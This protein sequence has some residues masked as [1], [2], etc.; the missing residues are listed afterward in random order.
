MCEGV[1]FPW[2]VQQSS[3]GWIH[4]DIKVCVITH[5][6]IYEIISGVV[7]IHPQ[8]YRRGDKNGQAPDYTDNT[9]TFL[10]P[11]HTHTLGTRTDVREP[12]RRSLGAACLSW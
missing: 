5:T 1:Y 8:T 12:R 7:I 9:Q 3:K 6:H 4:T 2:C 10:D 11:P